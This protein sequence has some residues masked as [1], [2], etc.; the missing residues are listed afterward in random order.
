[1]YNFEKN[2]YISKIKKDGYVI[3]PNLLD[4]EECDKLVIKTKN[5]YLKNK[6]NSHISSKNGQESLRDLVLRDPKTYLHLIDI[7]KIINI[8]E[9]IFNDHFI[10]DN[11]MANNS[12]KVGN[13]YNTN[14]HIDSHLAV[15][16]FSLTL[17]VVVMI[18]CNDFDKSNGSTIVWKGS[19]NSGIRIQNFQQKKKRFRYK[20][21][22]LKAKAGS[23]IIF[24]GHVWHQTGKNINGLDRWTILNHY[25]RWWIKPATDFTNCGQ[26][27]FKLLNNKQKELFGFT[28]KSPKFNLLK[29][30]KKRFY[31]LSKIKNIPKSYIK[32]KNY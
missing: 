29:K 11:S 7:P 3:L 14:K 1:M 6:K 32:N 22:Y 30:T 23:A 12:C 8:L 16:N 18:C 20:K 26:K 10:L 21:I 9:N 27:I 5:L 24:L 25:K 2:K 4:K 31:T 13:N 28:S 15:K 19:Q 17:D